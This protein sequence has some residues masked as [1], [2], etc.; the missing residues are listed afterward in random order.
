MGA[1]CFTYLVIDI[2]QNIINKSTV[3]V[4]KQSEIAGGISGVFFLNIARLLQKVTT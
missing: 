4:K 2:D 3:F 1:F